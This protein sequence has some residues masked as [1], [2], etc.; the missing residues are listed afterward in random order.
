MGPEEPDRLHLLMFVPK[1]RGDC[2]PGGMN[3]D[4]P[5][6][7]SECRWHLNHK[8]SSCILDV[9]DMGGANLEEVGALLGVSRE[10]ARQIEETALRKLL[11]R[12]RLNHWRGP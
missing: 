11:L 2:L 4:R 6:V 1:T 8:T 9:A 3:S 10:R 12:R 5:C 7:W